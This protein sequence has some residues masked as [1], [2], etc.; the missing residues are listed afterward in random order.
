VR[1]N[2]RLT[3]E[4][5]RYFVYHGARRH[6]ETWTWKSDP[7][8]GHGFGPWKPEWIAPTWAHVRAPML[9]IVGTEPDFFGPASDAQLDERLA[10]V[11][12]VARVR[13]PGTGHFVHMEQPEQTARLV[14]DFV[15]AR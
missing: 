14:L 12:D 10:H 8:I 6:G 7:R 1:T 4:W 13:V 15:A 11:K 2:T 9:A 3:P 5:L